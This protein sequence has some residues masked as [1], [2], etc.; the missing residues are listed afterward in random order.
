MGETINETKNLNL[1]VLL[2]GIKEEIK[3]LHNGQI[4]ET[5]NG[6]DAEFIVN[7]KGVYRIEVFNESPA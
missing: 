1:K 7:K 6:M 5:N 3:L 2:P 4:I